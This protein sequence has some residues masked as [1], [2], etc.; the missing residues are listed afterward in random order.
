MREGLVYA[1]L[2]MTGEDT[3]HR[4]CLCMSVYVSVCVCASVFFIFPDNK[5]VELKLT[6]LKMSLEL[7]GLL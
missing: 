3:V 2:K 1:V 6:F 5:Y 7:R 4:T